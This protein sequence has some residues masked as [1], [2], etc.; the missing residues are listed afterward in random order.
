MKKNILALLFIFTTVSVFSQTKI[1]L[2][3][4]DTLLAK[5][6]LNIDKYGL[7]QYIP[8]NADSVNVIKSSEIQLIIDGITHKSISVNNFENKL[9]AFQQL[10]FL[11]ATDV[12]Q[13][14]FGNAN[15]SFEKVVFNEYLG[16]KLHFFKNVYKTHKVPNRYRYFAYYSYTNESYYD[17]NKSWLD[18]SFKLD[19]KIYLDKTGMFK[20]YMAPFYEKGQ[21]NAELYSYTNNPESN[22]ILIDRKETKFSYG[23]GGIKFGGLFTSKYNFYISPEFGM[24][25]KRFYL[26]PVNMSYGIMAF[27][28]LSIGYNFKKK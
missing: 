20:F 24:C 8:D 3:N 18:W 21:V 14:T 16:I 10:N 22:V 5:K 9:F 23:L 11:L 17:A 28:N 25:Y 1:L 6:I 15:L 4:G 27:L 2:N 7:T 26:L 12:G 13:L 19:L